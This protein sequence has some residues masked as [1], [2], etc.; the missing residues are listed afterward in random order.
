MPVR[1]A[2]C[3]VTLSIGLLVG[4]VAFNNVTDYAINL[5]FV[6]H[7]LAMDSIP[8]AASIVGRAIEAPWMHHAAYVLVIAAEA[9]TALLCFAG[10]WRMWRARRATVDAF[11]HAS[12]LAIH[13][14]TLG[15]VLFVAGFL[16]IAG[17]WFG[18][19]MAQEWNAQASAFRFAAVI[20]F[21]LVLVAQPERS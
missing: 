8:S 1:T 10:A 12:A 11:H 14:L 4:I 5:Q 20:L 2:K 6:R 19:W 15:A 13:G 21:G 3:L 7:V 17:E 9:A 18:M 16:A